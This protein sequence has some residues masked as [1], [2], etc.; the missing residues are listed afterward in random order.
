M[1]NMV[2]YGSW[3]NVFKYIIH[4]RDIGKPINNPPI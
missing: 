2:L 4:G 3:K 1:R